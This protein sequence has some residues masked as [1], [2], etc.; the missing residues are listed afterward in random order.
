MYA[1]LEFEQM[2][3]YHKMLAEIEPLTK[4]LKVLGEYN[5]G[6]KLQ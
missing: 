2:E 5:Q 1:D 6:E 3:D 4:E